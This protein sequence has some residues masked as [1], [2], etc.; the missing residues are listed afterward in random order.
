MNLK[1]DLSI[2]NQELLKEIEYKI[3]DKEYSPEEIK[4][5]ESYIA[6]HIMSLSSKNGDIAKETAKFN[7]LINVLVKNEE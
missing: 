2:K 1:A 5:C 7:D 6:N 4:Q 3:E